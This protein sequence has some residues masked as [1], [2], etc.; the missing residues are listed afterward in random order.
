MLSNT[1]T[2]HIRLLDY[3]VP[4]RREL[5]SNSER[6]LRCC[7]ELSTM[8]PSR[9]DSMLCFNALK[10]SEERYA[11]QSWKRALVYTLALLAS[12]S[13]CSRHWTSGA[14]CYFWA[15]E[16]TFLAPWL[17]PGEATGV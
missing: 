13:L 3:Q 16:A 17:L 4:T 10:S 6:E 2:D 14:P 12:I 5:F 11:R 1:I 7:P 15:G 8:M 9:S